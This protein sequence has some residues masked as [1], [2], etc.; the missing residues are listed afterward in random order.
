MHLQKEV[1]KC[2][3]FKSGDQDLDL[4][5]IP[6]FYSQAPDE[7]TEN[8]SEDEHV[9]RKARL[10]W[11]MM[12]R[13]KLAE[14]EKSKEEIRDKVE[15]SI[16]AKSDKLNDL[17]PQLAK[18][19]QETK[20][21]QTFLEMPLD[22]DRNQYN[23][24]KALPRPLFVLYSQASA[25]S[26]ACDPDGIEIVVNGDLE[27]AKIINSKLSNPESDNNEEPEA[28][29]DEQ[30][31]KKRRRNNIAEKSPDKSMLDVHPLSV[32]VTVKR[33][34]SPESIQLDFTYVIALKIVAVKNKLNS[35][36]EGNS[37]LLS[38]SGILNHLIRS[39]LGTESPNPS[40]VYKLKKPGLP[41]WFVQ[42]RGNP[43]IWA[44]T[45][46]GLDFLSD[47][48][49]EAKE[50]ICRLQIETIIKTI[51]SRLF[52]RLA[53]QKQISQFE[54]AKLISCSNY[55]PDKFAHEFPSRISCRIRSLGPVEFEQ[56]DSLDVT[57]H[58]T[59]KLV[60][61]NDFIYRL[62]IDRDPNAKLIALIAIKPDYPKTFPIFCLNLHWNGE[63]NIHNNEPLRV[64]FLFYGTVLIMGRLW[65]FL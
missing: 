44:Q 35:V 36:K 9:Q 59:E 57:H 51:R 14:E 32:S 58:L 20:P 33:K 7:I 46:S 16:R 63:Y 24:A 15:N 40:T 3:E 17:K 55:I 22:E 65:C 41:D 37:V 19:L 53:L 1:T 21:V 10:Q 8:T 18:I 12:T 34:D 38:S 60:D 50:E 47:D 30:V 43:Y 61:K 45:I 54:K 29:D 62:Q 39:D 2:I 13:K 4:I 56:Y 64:R 6:D 48:S 27:E 52:S 31:K 11:E 23:S 49:D 42:D 5:S 26:R 28:D 25:Y